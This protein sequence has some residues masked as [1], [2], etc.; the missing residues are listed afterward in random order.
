[1]TINPE[2]LQVSHLDA[3]HESTEQRSK[4]YRKYGERVA[5]VLT[6]HCAKST[7]MA[8]ALPLSLGCGAEAVV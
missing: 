7:P 3:M 1:M 8:V 4:A 5:E 6:K 2:G